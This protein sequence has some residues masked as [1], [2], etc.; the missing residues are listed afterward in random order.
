MTTDH[1]GPRAPTAR[2]LPVRRPRT[3]IGAEEF[4]RR[5][6]IHPELL[7]RLIR[8]GLVA[9]SRDAA[10]ALVLRPD[11]LAT[12]ARIQRL[13]TGL[14]LNYAAVGVVLDL[15]DRIRVLE[16][17]LR[18]QRGAGARFPDDSGTDERRTDAGGTTT[19]I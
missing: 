13:R 7:A 18:R 10:G 16:L 19:W 8:L 15:L 1:D 3:L 9:A 12:V 6:G 17:A 14:S 4:A 5:C 2:H 11:E